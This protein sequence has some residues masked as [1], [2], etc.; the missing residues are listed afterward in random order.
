MAKAVVK[1]TGYCD[2]CGKARKLSV[3]RRAGKYRWL[4]VRCAEKKEEETQGGLP[5]TARL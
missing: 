1:M 3:H 2:Y 5:K 4:C